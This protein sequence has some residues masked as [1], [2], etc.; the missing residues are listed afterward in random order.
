MWGS[1]F[2]PVI[3]YVNLKLI[4][5]SSCSREKLFSR[6]GQKGSM[7]AQIPMDNDKAQKTCKGVGQYKINCNKLN[8]SCSQ[9]QA[10][11]SERET[12]WLQLVPEIYASWQQK[13]FPVSSSSVDL[14]VGQN[15]LYL[16]V[17]QHWVQSIDPGPLNNKSKQSR[18]KNEEHTQ[19]HTKGRNFKYRNK[20]WQNGKPEWKAALEQEWLANKTITGLIISLVDRQ[21]NYNHNDPSH[22]NRTKWK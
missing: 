15:E 11:I 17:R 20:P 6:W 18:W 2:S 1:Y 14:H 3:K 12:R 4:W 9:I 8:N 16:S 22:L 5:T 21:P 7:H 10:K 19:I 13:M